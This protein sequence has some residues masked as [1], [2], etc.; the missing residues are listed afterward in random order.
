MIRFAHSRRLLFIGSLLLSVTVYS[1]CQNF[2]ARIDQRLNNLADT[3]LATVLRTS[4]EKTGGIAARSQANCIE[5]DAIATVFDPNGNKSLIEQQHGVTETDTGFMVSV[6]S[7]DAKG[8]WLEQLNLKGKVIMVLQG[9]EKPF[10]EKD[11]A[12]LYGSAVKL[13]LLAQAL[14]GASGLLP[15][16][17]LA[18]TYAGLDRKGGR[19]THKIE[20]V[21]RMFDREQFPAGQENA[22][23]VAWINAETF[24]LERLWLRYPLG[25]NKFGYLA[26]NINKYHDAGAGLILPSSIEFVRSDQYQ[27]FSE[28]RIMT[29]EYQQFRP[30]HEEGGLLAKI[31]G[32]KQGPVSSGREPSNSKKSGPAKQ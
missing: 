5:G 28:E 21:G 19:L 18:V 16:K 10:Y 20:A 8:V 6:T 31:F 25:D 13:R 22:M 3:R 2:T 1:G 7:L 15:A 29:V 23:L 4:I 32:R 12:A 9:G 24:L 14:T 26:A 17:N 30:T 27:Q 11:T